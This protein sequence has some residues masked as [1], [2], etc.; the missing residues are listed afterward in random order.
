MRQALLCEN[1]DSPSAG[2][3][4]RDKTTERLK[5]AYYWPGMDAD[6][7]A[8]VSSCPSC[9]LHKPNNQS[10][11]GLL[12][13]L[14]VP[15]HPWESVSLDFT[16]L[17]RDADG[18]DFALV[19]VCRLTKMIKICPTYTTVTA[20]DVAQL[21]VDSLLRHGYGIPTSLISDRDPRFTGKFWQSLAAI[22]GI[23]LAMSTANHPQT[24]G[25]TERANRSIKALLQQA[26]ADNGKDWVCKLP[27]LEFAYNNSVHPATGYS[28]FYLC[29]GR[30]PHLPSAFSSSIP[31][32][33]SE[34]A[35]VFATRVSSV[36]VD[37]RRRILA[38]QERMCVQADRSRRPHTFAV[39]DLVLLS[40]ADFG[41]PPFSPR[42]L[43]P[44]PVTELVSDVALRLQLPLSLSRR[45][46]VF[47]AAKLRP[48]HEEPLFPR[49]PSPLLTPPVQASAVPSSRFTV[50]EIA[51]RRRI[52]R[53][54]Q[55]L[56]K[57][58][59]YPAESDDT[60]EPLSRM[61]QDVPALV[62]A[63]ELAAG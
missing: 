63:Y 50:R 35:D 11:I 30:H 3:L 33:P 19:F 37:A 17:P 21:L 52:G 34:A 56:V 4:G 13:P 26:T 48:F 25:Q 60:W 15:H 20:P 22:L 9:Q 59:G 54:W 57:W 46:A 10:P 58:E 44:F 28:P 38:A 39:G 23:K 32:G 55:L 29:H 43:G 40:G 16:H 2:H 31:P 12:H 62:R 24:D 45:H 18:H 5:R 8:Y 53:G 47:H 51:G 7:A 27:L 61:R 41:L 1:H 14:P 42:Y 49:P 6:V 36:V